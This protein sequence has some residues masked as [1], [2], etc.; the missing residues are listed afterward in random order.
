MATEGLGAIMAP[1]VAL[2]G[3]TVLAIPLFRRLGLGSV[4]GYFAAG[5]VVGPFGLGLFNDP[6][7]MLHFA[8]LGVVLFLFIIGLELRPA[9]LWA[10]RQQIFGV[11]LL[12]VLTCIALL[13]VTCMG[14]GYTLIVSFVASSGFVLSST[15]VIMSMLRE[16]GELATPDGQK[17]VAILLFEDLMIVPLLA[18]IAL[19]SPVSSGEP[20]N[21]WL[22]FGIAIG[23][24]AG[25]LAAG[26][27]LMDPMFA[28]LA[29]AGSREAMSAGALLVVLGAALLMDKAGLS[30]A[31]GAF[32]AGVM[33]SGSNYRHQIEADI[34]PFRGILMGLFFLSVGMAL[35]L[36]IVASQL[37]LVVSSVIAAMLVKGL[38]VYAVARL[39]GSTSR[40]AIR[41]TVLFA[42]GG[43][44]AFVLYTAA[45]TASILTPEAEALFSAVVILSMALTPLAVLAM[46]RY[47]PAEGETVDGVETPENLH[48]RALLIGFGR[49]G[50]VASQGLLARGVEVSIIDTDTEMIRAA[51]ALGF[52]VYYGDGSRLDILHAS[53]AEEAE[54]ILVCVDNPVS[55]N[56]IVELAKSH[57][58]QAKLL[59]R[60]ID[61]RHAIELRG[62]GVDFEIRDTLESAMQMVRESMIEIGLDDEEADEVLNDL[63]SRDRRR[64]AMQASGGMLEGRDLLHHNIADS[65][66]QGGGK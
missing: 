20:T 19:L 61:R 60:A 6:Q 48:G 53:G 47:L 34:E 52:K 3:A 8:E 22:D 49:F 36:G 64:M 18:I 51:E 17:S 58:P 27:W 39:T 32:L 9:R 57:F 59:V 29:R 12:Q 1:A 33:L 65:F 11:G 63:R 46:N 4:L 44:F 5:V 13:T 23:A 56:L 16:Q 7:A 50:Q 41:R 42:Q 45:G 31:M 14:F 15:A 2:L 26:R 54:L 37:G 55:A 25:L 40:A 30:T 21:L 10:M 66:R 38:G 24:I 35:E 43:E 62:A 28:L